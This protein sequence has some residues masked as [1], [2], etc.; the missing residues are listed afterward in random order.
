MA[1]QVTG[2]KRAFCLLAVLTP[3]RTGVGDLL[4]SAQGPKRVLT[5]ESSLATP[6][7]PRRPSLSMAESHCRIP[8]K[9]RSMTLWILIPSTVA[10]TT[11]GKGSAA[12]IVAAIEAEI[13]AGERVA[14]TETPLT[15]NVG[16]VTASATGTA[17]GSVAPR[18]ARIAAGGTRGSAAVN[19]VA[20]VAVSRAGRG[21]GTGA[22]TRAGSG[23]G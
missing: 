8:P 13:A 18:A 22:G 9:T 21:A 7:P 15:T 14:G 17:T 20:V 19:G 5:G 4:P 6:T 3:H 2:R 23:A 1:R 10:R 12:R 16:G 11:R